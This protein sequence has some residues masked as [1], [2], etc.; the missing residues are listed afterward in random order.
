MQE[1]LV[2]EKIGNDQVGPGLDKALAF[3][4]VDAAAVDFVAGHG[5]GDAADPL[6]LLDFHK[7]VAK[8]QKLITLQIMIPNDALNH[9]LLGEVYVVIQGAVNLLSQKSSQPQ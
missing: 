3:P 2:P 7:S 1:L 4:L 5:H 6:D 9:H 8:S